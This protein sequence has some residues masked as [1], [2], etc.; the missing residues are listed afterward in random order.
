MDRGVAASPSS[1]RAI[2]SSRVAATGFSQKVGMPA[3]SACR[4]RAACAGG[5]GRDDEGV[6][7]RGEEAVDVGGVAQALLGGDALGERRVEVGH[8][9]LVDGVEPRQG[10]AW[11]APMRPT[12]ASP[13][14]IRE[15]FRAAD[16]PVNLCQDIW[17]FA[18]LF[19]TVPLT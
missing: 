2:V 5:R 4:S 12:P 3:A 8:D 16:P 19:A 14:L 7:A 9:H 17:S 18:H 15:L 6:E 10:A 1:V 11:K 13:I